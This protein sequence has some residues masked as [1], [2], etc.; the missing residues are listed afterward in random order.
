M[1]QLIEDQRQLLVANY[2]DAVV[3]QLR[4]QDQVDAAANLAEKFQVQ[5]WSMQQKYNVIQKQLDAAWDQLQKFNT[6]H[7]KEK[8]ND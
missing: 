6:T 4:A 3:R 1:N 8:A 7:P 5:M 2:H